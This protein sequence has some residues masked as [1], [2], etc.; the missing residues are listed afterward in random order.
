[1]EN[2][3]T[4]ITKSNVTP[5]QSTLTIQNL[6]GALRLADLGH[7]QRPEE[8]NQLLNQGPC[9]ASRRTVSKDRNGEQ[10]PGLGV[11]VSAVAET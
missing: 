6:T 1:V 3:T 9:C 2:L 10:D 7:D 5:L 11:Q 8:S 4:R